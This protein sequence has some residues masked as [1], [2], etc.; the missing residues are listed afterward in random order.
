MSDVLDR[1]RGKVGKDN[2]SESVSRDECGVDS[3]G[4]PIRRVI[5]DADR[6]FP[7]HR[8]TGSRCDFVIFFGDA[9]ERRVVT[10]PL[11]LKSGRVDVSQ[12]SAQLQR[13]ADFAAHFVPSTAVCHPVLIH[14]KKINLRQLNRAKVKFRDMR[15][16]IRTARCNRGGNLALAL[17]SP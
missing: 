9:D 5:V 14:G 13:G 2:L 4:L 12:A 1:I 3:T 7:A 10:V 15:L 17:A 6:A 11:E 16:T 8:W